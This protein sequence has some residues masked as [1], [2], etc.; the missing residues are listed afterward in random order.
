[1][2]VDKKIEKNATYVVTKEIVKNVKKICE[3]T[4]IAMRNARRDALDML[5]DLKKENKSNSGLTGTN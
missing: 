1:M 5:K 3:D 4:K 2:S